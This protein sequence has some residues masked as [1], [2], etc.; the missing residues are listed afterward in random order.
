MTQKTCLRSDLVIC[1]CRQE[2]GEKYKNC[3]EHKI[4]HA[5]YDLDIMTQEKNKLLAVLRL[6]ELLG[7]LKSNHYISSA[8]AR[9]SD[10]LDLYDEI[11]TR[12]N[13]L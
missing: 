6:K 13:N 10:L 4:I 12:I 11:I 5:W 3:K 1:N 2:N 7:K 8:L 9:D